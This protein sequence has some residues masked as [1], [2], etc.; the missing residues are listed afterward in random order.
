MNEFNETLPLADFDREMTLH[1]LLSSI[2]IESLASSIEILLGDNYCLKTSNDEVV[3][4]RLLT[5]ETRLVEIR[6]EL[7]SVGC[8][9]VEKNI[10][11]K[12][13]DAVR[14]ILELL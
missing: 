11:D 2:N 1:E 4:G 13:V 6:P 9:I 14:K 3:M 8:L 12:L 7:E 5:G 10:D